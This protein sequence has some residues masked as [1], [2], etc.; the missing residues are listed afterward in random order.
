MTRIDE[1]I[2]QIETVINDEECPATLGELMVMK[3][4]LAD[5][6]RQYTRRQ[7]NATTRPMHLSHRIFPG[8]VYDCLRDYERRRYIPYTARPAHGF[9]YAFHVNYGTAT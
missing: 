5:I 1:V 3:R 6:T 8:G 2:H 9:R 4:I 7:D